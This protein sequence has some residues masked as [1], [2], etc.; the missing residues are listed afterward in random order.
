M[1][2]GKAYKLAPKKTK[3]E[4]EQDLEISTEFLVWDTQFN[5]NNASDDPT[6]TS[7]QDTLINNTAL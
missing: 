6:A 1:S 7:L 2:F 3:P 5:L 4:S